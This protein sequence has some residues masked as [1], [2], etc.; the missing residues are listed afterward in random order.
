MEYLIRKGQTAL[1][2]LDVTANGLPLAEFDPD[3]IEF[4]FGG[5]Q[6]YLSSGD[7]FLDVDENCY[8]VFLTQEQTFALPST[9]PMQ[10]RVL[11]DGQVGG[12]DITY[13]R[14]G[15]SLSNAVLPNSGNEVVA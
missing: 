8:A 11:K 14:I 4:S 15:S 6:Y 3:E 9:A 10:V 1:I 13:W 7:V 12:T 2:W 5:V